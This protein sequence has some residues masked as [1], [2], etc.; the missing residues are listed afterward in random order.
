M[1]FEKG[2]MF[3]MYYILF[4]NINVNHLDYILFNDT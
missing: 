4:H 1:E 2:S 3:F